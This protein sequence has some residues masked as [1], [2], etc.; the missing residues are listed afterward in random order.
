MKS[1]RPDKYRRALALMLL[2]GMS[3][4]CSVREQ[5]RQSVRQELKS[6]RLQTDSLVLGRRQETRDASIQLVETVRLSPP[7]TGG[8]Q[9][10]TAVERTHTVRNLR[11]A[12]QDSLMR[13]RDQS[14]ARQ[15]QKQA[16]TAVQKE[17]KATGGRLRQVLFGI[18]LTAGVLGVWKRFRRQSGKR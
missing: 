2:A 1:R 3:A 11:S 12:R 10:V 6:F 18:V 9:H 15:V 4:G 17:K 16:D 7:D 8:Q 5:V 14:A 13:R